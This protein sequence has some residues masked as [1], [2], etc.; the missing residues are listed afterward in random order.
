MHFVQVFIVTVTLVIIYIY[1]YMH[2]YI[3]IYIYILYSMYQFMMLLRS[4]IEK[5]TFSQ[6]LKCSL[7]R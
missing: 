7:Q 1:I 4:N 3:Y 6:F 2:I 5:G